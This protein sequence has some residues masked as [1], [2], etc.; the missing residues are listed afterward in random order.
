MKKNLPES[1]LQL[2]TT[3]EKG[4]NGE[5]EGEGGVWIYKSEDLGFIV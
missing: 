4:R 5:M 2:N 1:E 3:G